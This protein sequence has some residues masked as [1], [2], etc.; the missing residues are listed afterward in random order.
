MITTL[1]KIL[2][3]IKQDNNCQELILNGTKSV[4]AIM[5]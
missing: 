5:C 2:S 1:F 4:A 3:W